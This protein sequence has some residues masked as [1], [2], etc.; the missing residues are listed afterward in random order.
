MD[1]AVEAAQK[2]GAL[3]LSGFGK[4]MRLWEKAP[5]AYVTDFDLRSE[6]LI[7]RHLSR[8]A[9]IGFLGEERGGHDANGLTWVVDPWRTLDP[10]PVPSPAEA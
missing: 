4:P 5:R 1:L 8:A 2:A 3:Q 7:C 10:L 9:G 6:E